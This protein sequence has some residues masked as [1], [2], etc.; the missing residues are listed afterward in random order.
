MRRRMMIGWSA[1][2]AAFDY[3]IGTVLLQE[4]RPV[5]DP[6]ADRAR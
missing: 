4:L 3:P 6:G 1:A 5:G 2:G